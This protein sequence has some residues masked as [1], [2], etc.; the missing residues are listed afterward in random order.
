MTRR[1]DTVEAR[2]KLKA[3]RTPYWH[4]LSTGC[5]VGYRRMSTASEGTWVA[6]VYDPATRRQMRRS[7]GGF[8]EFPT[9]RR[10]DEA[11][12]AAEAWFEHM[13]KGGTAD[14]VTVRQACE[15]Y[16]AHIRERK[17]N[18]AATT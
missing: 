1:I 7:L 13:G 18:E 10:F 14:T 17:G 12:K 3:R 8:E 9:H 6:Q 5:H 16:V 4:R 15:R 11:K 2:S